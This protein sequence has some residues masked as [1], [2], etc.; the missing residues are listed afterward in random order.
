MMI[1]DIFKVPSHGWFRALG[2]D[3]QIG[4]VGNGG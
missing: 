4:Y 1:V 2:P 3:M